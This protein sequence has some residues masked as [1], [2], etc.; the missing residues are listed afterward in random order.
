MLTRNNGT[1]EQKVVAQPE[2][3]EEALVV[4]PVIAPSV[5][6]LW[7]AIGFDAPLMSPRAVTDAPR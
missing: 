4:A 7:Q 3:G 2:V 6:A 5:H 1:D